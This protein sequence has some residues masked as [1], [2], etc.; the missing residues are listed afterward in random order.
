MDSAASRSLPV[1]TLRA[2][3]VAS[4]AAQKKAK[5]MGIGTCKDRHT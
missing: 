5:E 3:E 1:L 2:A 4:E